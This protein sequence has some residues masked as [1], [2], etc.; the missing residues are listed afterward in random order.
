MLEPTRV[1]SVVQLAWGAGEGDGESKDADPRGVLG[2]WEARGVRG[3]ER[4]CGV[5]GVRGVRGVL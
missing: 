5:R 4:V 2:V 3:V 1:W